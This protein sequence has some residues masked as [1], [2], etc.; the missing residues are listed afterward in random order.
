MA[1]KVLTKASFQDQIE[2]GVT[3]VD[4]WAAWC[5]P[6]KIQL[7]IIEELA[8]EVKGKA[9]IAKVNADEEDNLTAQFG[10]SGIPTLL[11]FKDGEIVDRMVGVRSKEELAAK[12]LRYT[13][14]L[15]AASCQSGGCGCEH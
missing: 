8:E 15:N 6:C 12:I 11:L 7:P 4:F 3:L 13:D 1:V 10:I 5:G 9:T 14:D 2:K